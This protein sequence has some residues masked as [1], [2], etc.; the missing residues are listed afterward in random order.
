MGVNAKPTALIRLTRK[1][2]SPHI[3][4]PRLVRVALTSPTD[5]ESVLLAAHLLRE[6]SSTRIYPDIPWSERVTRH[7][8]ENPTA[9]ADRNDRAIFIHGVPE[10]NDSN[11][12]LNYQHDCGEW[13]YIQEALQTSGVF[14]TEVTRL[15][16]SPNYKGNGPR[17]LKI[18][19]FSPIMVTQ[20]LEAWY[21]HRKTVP[22]ELRL[23]PATSPT[24]SRIRPNETQSGTSD[25]LHQDNG[26]GSAST[27]PPQ[28]SAA[29]KNAPL[30]VSLRPPT[31]PEQS[32]SPALDL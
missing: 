19:L 32:N 21:K 14:T 6:T 27:T 18:N 15:P 28:N 3:N 2:H 29:T 17:I 12:Q 10:L 23:R 7:T 8:T 30:P 25:L 13:K 24:T 22:P 31:Q 5:V 26:D 20:V 4:E 11:N 16:T 9:K 1:P